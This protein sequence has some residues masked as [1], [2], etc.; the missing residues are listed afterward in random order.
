MTFVYNLKPDEAEQNLRP[1]VRSK[2]FETKIINPFSA[3]TALMLMQ[4]GSIQA[5][6]LRSNLF[7]TQYSIPNKNK[8]DFKVLNADD[9]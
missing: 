3:G 5:A 1:C 9:I 6:G 4:T 7:V 2:L 8:L